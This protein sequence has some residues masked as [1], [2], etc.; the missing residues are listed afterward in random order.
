MT[1]TKHVLVLILLILPMFA[2]A[3]SMVAGPNEVLMNE[4]PAESMLPA[5]FTEETL[6]VA[7]YAEMDTSL[8][9]Y[10]TG[11]VYTNYSANVI[12][13][14]ESEGYAVTALTT[15]DILDH[16]L[17]AADFDS[18]VL[19]NQLPKD[20]IINMVKDYWL[21]GG[22]ILSFGG[23]IGFC[24]YTGMIDTSL[25]GDFQLAPIASPGYWAYDIDVSNVS[26]MQRHPVT[27]DYQVSDSTIMPAGNYTVFNGMGLAGIID[28]E[29][30]PLVRPNY[31]GLTPVAAG[32]DNPDQG[33]KIIHLPGN[34]NSIPSWFNPMITESID[35][36]AP[37]PKAH[38]AIDYT[39]HPFYGVDSWDENVSYGDKFDIWRDAV[40]NHSS[41]FDKLYGN[42]LT[43][44]DLAPFDVLIINMP[45][46]NYTAAEITVIQTWVQNGG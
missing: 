6:K 34:C 27:Q 45:S 33:G 42:E 9:S 39:H 19:V 40:V 15:Q 4:A 26:I 35:W 30:I 37:R 46:V 14:L 25:A 7:V 2:L 11:G 20:T 3:P 23:S 32:F 29:F 24:F 38:V 36:L 21:G 43:A 28:T 5:Q 18:F 41:T 10:A 17:L 44:D 12:S 22:G 8:P 16:K 31:T 1:R 13:L